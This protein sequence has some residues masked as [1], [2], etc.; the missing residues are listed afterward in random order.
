VDQLAS[1]D[2][3]RLARAGDIYISFN[4]VQPARGTTFC[5]GQPAPAASADEN[6]PRDWSREVDSQSIGWARNML[7][8]VGPAPRDL[9]GTYCCASGRALA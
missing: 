1:L 6:W 2:L 7:E 4:D 3:K 8:H 9:A 5:H